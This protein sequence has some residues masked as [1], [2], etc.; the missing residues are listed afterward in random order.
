MYCKY[1]GARIENDA[2]YCFECGKKTNAIIEKNVVSIKNEDNL[3]E[4]VK[5]KVNPIWFILIPI[6]IIVIVVSSTIP[7][8]IH[9]NNMINTQ[10]NYLNTDNFSSDYFI[11][12]IVINSSNKITVTFSDKLDWELLNG[13][14]INNHIYIM[15]SGA[16]FNMDTK[17]YSLAKGYSLYYPYASYWVE[18]FQE[19][20]DEYNI[21]PGFNLCVYSG[22]S[23]KINKENVYNIEETVENGHFEENRIYNFGI[24]LINPK[25]NTQYYYDSYFRYSNGELIKVTKDDISSEDTYF[26][27]KNGELHFAKYDKQIDG[28]PC[29]YI[30]DEIYSKEQNE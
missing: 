11:D 27:W 29:F 18:P 4:K 16:E 21:T 8:I 25:G 23:E 1:C 26:I 20:S 28:I 19:K 30:Y 10:L 9:K 6:I 15:E 13:K 2:S 17:E 14:K 12:S 5:K 7:T 3:K 22:Y 24:E